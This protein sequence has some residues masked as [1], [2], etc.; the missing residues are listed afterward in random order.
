[1]AKSNS[2]LRQARSSQRKQLRNQFIRNRVHSGLQRFKQLLKDNPQEAVKQGR[3]VVSWLDRASK[4]STLHSNKSRR[5]KARVMAQ[6]R[7]LSSSVK[8]T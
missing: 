8:P 2:A 5:Y 4:S 7:S 3:Q 1:M 6:L